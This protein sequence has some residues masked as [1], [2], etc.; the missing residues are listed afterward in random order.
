M[1]ETASA[2]LC[3]CGEARFQ[4]LVKRW[5][6]T[7]R[8]GGP[9]FLT[10]VYVIPDGPGDLSLGSCWIIAVNRGMVNGESCV[11]YGCG[12]VRRWVGPRMLSMMVVYVC[13]IWVV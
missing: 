9:H 2:L 10:I 4:I 3:V 5:C 8:R 7:V 13:S 11:L 12:G 1:G 6:K